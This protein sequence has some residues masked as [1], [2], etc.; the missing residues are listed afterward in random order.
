MSAADSEV[1]RLFEMGD[2][3][4]AESNF[5]EA[6]RL[7][8]EAAQLRTATD[9][10]TGWA[11]EGYHYLAR[12]IDLYFNDQTEAALTAVSQARER[13]HSSSRV[14]Q[15]GFCTAL[16]SVFRA[17]GA[18]EADDYALAHTHLARAL[19]L[20]AEV[21][22]TDREHAQACAFWRDWACVQIYGGQ[23]CD[24]DSLDSEEA[25]ALHEKLGI[26]LAALVERASDARAKLFF[27]LCGDIYHAVVQFSSAIEAFDNRLHARSVKTF[28]ALLP[29]LQSSC[30]E[31][32]K[33]QLPTRVGPLIESFQ[34]LEAMAEGAARLAQAE[35]FIY[36]GDHAKAARTAREAVTVLRQ[37]RSQFT[38]SIRGGLGYDV[39]ID[40]LV[41]EAKRF[42]AKLGGRDP[43]ILTLESEV[44]R[45]VPTELLDETLAQMRELT[46]A[47]MS[48]LWVSS[49][50]L[51]G[52]LLETLLIVAIM[53]K[54][55]PE[56]VRSEQPEGSSQASLTLAQLISE[57]ESG[58]L[59]PKN[60]VHLSHGLRDMRNLLHPGKRLR[61]GHHPTGE[62]TRTA[63]SVLTLVIRH[64]AKAASS[65]DARPA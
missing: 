1:L 21:E 62:E 34:F 49:L 23:L 2:R 37:R 42:A 6:A 12:A 22:Y 47:V 13:F 50:A 39:D 11:I 31:V 27:T 33:L 56:A 63:C 44:A 25:E 8:A 40:E 26:H 45:I 5:A 41:D 46:N 30:A 35:M 61:D 24:V 65:Q 4:L 15:V 60:L 57:A 9:R 53:K 38:S 51:C 3:C 58:G 20:L 29:T 18:H 19:P 48:G 43:G 32:A 16:E 14:G 36:L 54:S 10:T 7:F 17:L 55:S 52:G 28:A 59:L 64:L